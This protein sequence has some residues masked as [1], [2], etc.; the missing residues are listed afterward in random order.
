MTKGKFLLICCECKA[1]LYIS[2]IPRDMYIEGDDI[3]LILV[4]AT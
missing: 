3:E 1:E 4:F 2:S